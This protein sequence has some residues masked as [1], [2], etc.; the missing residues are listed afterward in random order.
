[1]G[2]EFDANL[3][4]LNKPDPNRHFTSLSAEVARPECDELLKRL[5]A[6]FGRPVMKDGTIANQVAEDT[7]VRIVAYEYQW[8][9]GNTRLLASC[10]WSATQSG[11]IVRDEGLFRWSMK[12]AHR[13]LTAKLQPRFALI[14]TR[15]ITYA[16]AGKTSNLDDLVAWFDLSRSRVLSTNLVILSDK[17]SFHAT[18]DR[19][20]FSITRSAY[21]MDYTINRISG[22]LAAIITENGQRVGS[23]AG[24]CERTETTVKKF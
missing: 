20:R 12:F 22:S 15:T 4:Y 18:S 7:F 3:A 9:M 8:D 5:T 24:T 17:D 2:H 23:I 6:A 11:E 1:L 21:V 10:F 19:I 16:A 13:S 14:C